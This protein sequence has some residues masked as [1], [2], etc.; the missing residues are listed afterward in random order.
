MC[1]QRAAASGCDLAYL[2]PSEGGYRTYASLGFVDALPMRIW[3]P[4]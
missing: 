3:V 1:L 2:N 4:D